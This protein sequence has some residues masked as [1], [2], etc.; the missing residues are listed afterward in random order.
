[1]K[2][3]PAI[4]DRLLEDDYQE[5]GRFRE[6][7]ENRLWKCL[8]MATGGE[9]LWNTWGYEDGAY[10]D[11]SYEE[12]YYPLEAVEGIAF[13]SN[14]PHHL[15]IF[16][17]FRIQFQFFTDPPDMHHHSIFGCKGILM[18]VMRSFTIP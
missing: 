4:F 17:L 3:Q 15:Y 10:Y 2:S 5:S 18:E 12:F 11:G 7:V 6:Y 16:W 13:I 1:M 14:S 9:G 8:V